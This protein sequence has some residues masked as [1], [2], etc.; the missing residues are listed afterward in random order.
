LGQRK[1]TGYRVSGL[2]TLQYH[3]KTTDILNEITLS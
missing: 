2:L 3:A 1:D